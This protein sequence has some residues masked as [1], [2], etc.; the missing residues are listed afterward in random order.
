MKAIAYTRVSTEDQAQHGV[1]LAAQGA[2]IKAYAELYDIQVVEYVED[3]GV[4]AKNLNRLGAQR[5][6]EMIKSRQVEAVIVAKLDRLTRSVRDLAD[7]VDLAN[8]KGVSLISVG[9]NLDTRSAAGRMVVGMLSVISQWER[10]AIGERTATS[11]RYKRSNGQIY[12][13]RYALYGYRKVDGCL[14]PVEAEQNAIQL[15]LE[16]KDR[17]SLSDI[18]QK[19]ISAG[20]HT[21]SGG[22]WNKKCIRKIIM[23]SSVRE[24]INAAYELRKAA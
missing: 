12:S 6:V 11:I 2:K 17:C 18:G 22:S 4:S 20:F 19:L 14:V 7:L 3:A 10:E 21:R 5:I 16:L 13:G 8:K 23:D 15:I 9:E 1:S 24:T